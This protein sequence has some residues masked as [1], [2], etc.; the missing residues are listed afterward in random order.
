VRQALLQSRDL[1]PQAIECFSDNTF[2]CVQ[3]LEE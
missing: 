1:T 2:F 3:A